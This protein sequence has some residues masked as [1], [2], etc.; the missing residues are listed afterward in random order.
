MQELTSLNNN[1]VKIVHSLHQKKYRNEL[2]LFLI[3]GYKGVDEAFKCGLSIEYVFVSKEYNRNLDQWPEDKIYL[4]SEPIM[5]KISTTDTPPGIV[6]VAK[7]HT[8][9]IEDVLNK[10]NP[11]LLF[12]E[13]IKDPGN[14]GTI[15]RTAAA[16]DVTGIILTD[17][18]VDIYNPKTVRSSAANLWKIPTV[19]IIEKQNL[20]ELINKQKKCQFLATMVTKDRKPVI[21]YN[22]DYNQPTVMMFGSEAEGLSQES[23]EM[24]DELIR[25]PMSEQVESLNLSISVGVVLYEAVRQRLSKG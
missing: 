6:A 8:Y 13:N 7:Q 17:D 4:V 22:I 16:A 10:T 5:K 24:A 21:Y 19:K 12:L 23:A 14:L 11:L 25:I 20:K 1:I 2:R 18:T 9:K 15:I 3:E